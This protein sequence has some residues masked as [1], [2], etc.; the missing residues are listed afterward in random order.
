[1]PFHGFQAALVLEAQKTSGF[2]ETQLVD[3]GIGG[4]AD[5]LLFGQ[6]NI[7]SLCVIFNAVQK[8][9]ENCFQLW[10]EIIWKSK[11]LR[12]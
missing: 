1:M 12:I 10:L 3:Q 9:I 5:Q 6:H 4:L 11:R 2:H 7:R 8:F